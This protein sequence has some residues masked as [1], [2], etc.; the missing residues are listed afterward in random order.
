MDR[1]AIIMLEGSVNVH[2]L[3]NLESAVNVPVSTIW[4]GG[5]VFSVCF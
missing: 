1:G 3:V 5:R 4:R 2:V